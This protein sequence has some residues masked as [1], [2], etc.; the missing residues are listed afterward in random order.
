MLTIATQ[1]TAK[2]ARLRTLSGRPSF[3]RNAEIN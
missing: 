2:T 1:T 3:T